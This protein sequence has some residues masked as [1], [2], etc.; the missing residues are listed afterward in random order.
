MGTCVL[1]AGVEAG[2]PLQATAPRSLQRLGGDPWPQQRLSSV[3]AR[4]KR[5]GSP[6]NPRHGVHSSTVCSRAKGVTS[7]KPGGG[8]GD[9]HGVVHPRSEV[10]S[11]KGGCDDAGRVTHHAEGRQAPRPRAVPLPRHGTPTQVNS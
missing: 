2:R 5:T 7:Q 10:L 3:S 6:P 1:L 8:G 9:E 4:E 11:L